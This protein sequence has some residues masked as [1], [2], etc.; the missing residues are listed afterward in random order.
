[1]Y[2]TSM[3]VHNNEETKIFTNFQFVNFF[4][5][6]LFPNDVDRSIRRII[7]TFFLSVQHLVLNFHSTG[8]VSFL[9]QRN[10]L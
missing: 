5:I 2:L 6:R 4:A 9:Y 7:A 1:M 3:S 10:Y 8:I